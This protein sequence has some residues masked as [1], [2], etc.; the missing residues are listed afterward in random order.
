MTLIFVLVSE[1]DFP[2]K[3]HSMLYD[4]LE[5]NLLNF[6]LFLL[7]FISAFVELLYLEP[8]P[9]PVRDVLPDVSLLWF[10]REHSIYQD[11]LHSSIFFL[12]NLARISTFLRVYLHLVS[13]LIEELS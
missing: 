11:H 6:R 13:H 1:E 5:N 9:V 2:L 10:Q 12:L 8:S 7:S 3:L 4:D